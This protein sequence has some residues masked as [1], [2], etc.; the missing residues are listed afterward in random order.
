MKAKD[1]M[2]TGVVTIR[3]DGTVEGA[4][5]L[6]LDNHISALPV[7]DSDNRLV[8]LISEGDIIRRMRDGGA[9]RRSWWLELFAGEADAKD[10]VKARSHK[11]ADVMTRDLVT[12]DEGTPVGEIAKTLETRRIKRVPVLRDEKIVGIVSRA[13][14]VRALA[15]S[16]KGKL[17]SPTLADEPLRKAVEAAIAEVPGASVN[18]INLIVENGNVSVWG[19]ADSD[20]V[21]NAIR[22]AAENVDGIRSVDVH[23]GR[24]P[25]WGYGI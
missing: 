2:K 21:E 4:V 14:L 12:V 16:T 18:L 17:P 11:V 13:D 10:Y 20:F 25:A 7:L 5:K 22:V 15:Q 8:G 1:V 23:M 24:L 3:D 19:V 6:M 9:Q